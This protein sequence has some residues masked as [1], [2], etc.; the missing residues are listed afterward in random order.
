MEEDD[1]NTFSAGHIYLW[2]WQTR[3]LICKTKAKRP[4]PTNSVGSGPNDDLPLQDADLATSMAVNTLSEN[5]MSACCNSVSWHPTIPN[6]L[7]SASDDGAVTVYVL[8]S[9]YC[10]IRLT[11]VAGILS[12][13]TLWECKLIDR[14]H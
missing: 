6:M 4:N 12:K 1:A 2:D 10:G 5:E 3:D 7:V 8:P 13:T 9:S 11:I 14:C